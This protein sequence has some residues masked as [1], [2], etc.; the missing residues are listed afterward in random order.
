MAA[1]RWWNKARGQISSRGQTRLNTLDRQQQLYF[2]DALRDARRTALHDAEAFEAILLTLERLGRFLNDGRGRGL[3]CYKEVILHHAEASPLAKEI[4]KQYPE[5]HV[6]ICNLF[7]LVKTARNDAVHEGALARHHTAHAVNLAIVLEDAFMVES[8]QIGDFMVRTPVSAYM[9]QPLSFIRQ[10][11]LTNSFSY[12]PVNTG[13][14]HAPEWR[15]VSD[16]GIAKFLRGI[17]KSKRTEHL[18]LQLGK[19]V[20]Q[21][22]LTLLKP[23]I[24]SPDTLVLEALD[25]SDGFPVLVVSEE[26]KH[27]LGIATAFDLL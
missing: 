12:M 25:K 6:N 2:R 10:T 4:P 5:C 19:A 20:N 14:E 27:L 18:A 23:H 7:E 17:P 26:T 24:C 11:L 22:H 3:G 13:P 21:S 1:A 8:N 15:L 9:W 16:L